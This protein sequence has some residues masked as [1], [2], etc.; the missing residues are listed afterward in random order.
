MEAIKLGINDLKK[1]KKFLNRFGTPCIRDEN[2][3]VWWERERLPAV[4]EGRVGLAK[5]LRGWVHWEDPV[6]ISGEV[7]KE[8]TVVLIYQLIPFDFSSKKKKL[9]PFDSTGP[10]Y[11]KVHLDLDLGLY[12]FSPNFKA[13]YIYL[14]Q[15]IPEFGHYTTQV[16]QHNFF[17]W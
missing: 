11:T 16:W 7:Q 10:D 5:K 3:K 14:T 6:N 17:F 15:G 13:L 2:S 8:K 12:K 4:T 9:I 1:K